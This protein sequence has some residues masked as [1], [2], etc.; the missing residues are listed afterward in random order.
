MPYSS[1]VS[2]HDSLIEQLG[3]SSLNEDEEPIA[4]YIIG[5]IDEDGY[6]RP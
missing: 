4:E 5:N 6:L 1:G 3:L 2:F